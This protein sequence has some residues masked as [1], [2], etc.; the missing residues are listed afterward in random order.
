MAMYDDYDTYRTSLIDFIHD[1][2]TG[3]PAND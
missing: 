3:Q 2:D 1:V